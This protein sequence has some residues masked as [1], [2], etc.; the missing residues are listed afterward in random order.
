MSSTG[1]HFFGVLDGF[2]G[3]RNVYLHDVAVIVSVQALFPERVHLKVCTFTQQRLRRK[4]T[5]PPQRWSTVDAHWA[6]FKLIEQTL[7]GMG[8]RCSMASRAFSGKYGSEFPGNQNPVD[9]DVVTGVAYA[10]KLMTNT[11]YFFAHQI[12]VTMLIDLFFRAVTFSDS[13]FDSSRTLSGN[14]AALFGECGV[15]D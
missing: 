12:P 8:S 4:D 14:R 1:E 6:L 2:I 5:M 7:L 15:S 10:L 3:H 9:S 13:C 11:G